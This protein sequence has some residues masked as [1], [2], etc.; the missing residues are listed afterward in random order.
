M[1][2]IG[3]FG[4]QIRFTVSSDKIITFEDFMETIS[5]RWAKH[6]VQGKLPRSEF[7]GPDLMAFTIKVELD[8]QY[9]V[10]PR[11]MRNKIKDCVRQGKKAYFVIGD[12]MVS[13][14]KFKITQAQ[15]EFKQIIG[16]GKITH[17]TMNLSFE[18]YI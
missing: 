13:K 5:A 7:L 9:G 16:K 17:I 12:H 3:N 11:K 4:S 1:A 6:N 14:N 2:L 10:N 8:A 18:E 15:N